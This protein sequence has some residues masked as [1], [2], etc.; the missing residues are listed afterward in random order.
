LRRRQR[1]GQEFLLFNLFY[2]IASPHLSMLLSFFTCDG[3]ASAMMGPNVRS[4]I[5]H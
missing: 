3:P 1:L 4:A 2:S 5:C